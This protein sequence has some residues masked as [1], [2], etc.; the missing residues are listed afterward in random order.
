MIDELKQC[1][2]PITGEVFGNALETGN[3]KN[4]RVLVRY[5]IEPLRQ[6]YQ[7][8][9]DKH[10]GAAVELDWTVRQHQWKKDINAVKGVKNI[11]AVASGKGGVGKSTVSVM[12][13][14]ALR[15]LGAR[16]GILDADIYG[17][18]MPRM[19]GDHGQPQSPDN[20]SFVP[21]NAGGIQSMSL[22]YLMEEKSAAIWRGAMVTRAMMQMLE[23]TRWDAVDYLIL[24]LPPGTGDIQLTMIQKIPVSA[25]VVIT[26][27]QDI[28]MIDAQ[29]ACAM[30]NKVDLPVLGVIENMSTYVCPACGHQEEIFGHGGADR[31]A[32]DFNTE[33]LGRLP[34]NI[35]IRQAMDAGEGADLWGV[36]DTLADTA[37]LIALRTAQ[38]LAQQ[39]VKLGV[40]NKL[41]LK[42]I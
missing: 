33:V 40:L 19:L 5:P 15:R 25:A 9:F 11:I 24:D 28:A 34:L 8:F 17:P 23:E 36:H 18:S 26:T 21:V 29:K 27:P 37:R 41:K 10:N 38:K 1:T 16:V 13:A 30:F 39:P 22:G 12:L 35:D 32:K 6:T 20:K 2:D 4:H 7:A 42:K 14:H 3:E 31:I